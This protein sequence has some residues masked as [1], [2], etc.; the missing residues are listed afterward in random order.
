MQKS[1]LRY[2]FIGLLLSTSVLILKYVDQKYNLSEFLF[3]KVEK[4]NS[5]DNYDGVVNT[6]KKVIYKIFYCLT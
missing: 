5:K 4:A 1:V 6:A 2:V 3:E